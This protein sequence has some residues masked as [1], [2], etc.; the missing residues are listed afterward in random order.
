MDF[1]YSFIILK[2]RLECEGRTRG[3]EGAAIDNVDKKG[4]SGRD[5]EGRNLDFPSSGQKH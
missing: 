2:E 1:V 4:K 5:S 3:G